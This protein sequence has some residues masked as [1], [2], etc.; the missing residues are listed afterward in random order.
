MGKYCELND[1]V[2]GLEVKL[3][4][5]LAQLQKQNQYQGQYQDQYQYQ[6]QWQAQGQYDTEKD[7]VI[8]K[9][10]GNPRVH[11]HNNHFLLIV[12]FIFVFSGGAPCSGSTVDN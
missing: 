10:I 7:T 11:L 12:I 3:E 5:I 4:K 9:D 8:L 6:N 2:A 1:R